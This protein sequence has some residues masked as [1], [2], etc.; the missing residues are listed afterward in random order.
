MTSPG[1]FRHDWRFLLPRSSLHGTVVLA[2]DRDGSA[3]GALG[4]SGWFDGVRDVDDRSSEPASVVVR[5]AD[6]VG[7]L[8]DLDRHVGDETVVLV[9]WPDRGSRLRHRREAAR[10]WGGTRAARDHVVFPGHADARWCAPVGAPAALRWYLDHRF[11]PGSRA[12][13]VAVAVVRLASRTPAAGLA[14]LAAPA[15]ITVWTPRSWGPA[16]VGPSEGLGPEPLL[17]SSAQDA[18]SRAVMLGFDGG[19]PT[20]LAK[21]STTPTT[22][23]RTVEEVA[24]LRLVEAV[25]DAAG[26][27]VTVPRS[28][29][30]GSMGALAWNRQTVVRGV[31]ADR[32]IGA[33]ARGS[34]LDAVTLLERVVDWSVAMTRASLAPESW[35]AAAVADRVVGPALRALEVLPAAEQP[36]DLA[37]RLEALRSRRP[38]ATIPHALAHADLAPCNVVV[39]GP[40]VGVVDWERPDVGFGPGD[41]RDHGPVGVDLS[42][43]ASYWLFQR[44][45]AT[46]IDDEVRLLRALLGAPA[47]DADADADP[48]RAARAAL[49][50]FH[51]AIGTDPDVVPWVWVLLWAQRLVASAARAEG[52]PSPAVVRNVAASA[53]FLREA[54]VALDAAPDSSTSS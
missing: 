40:V 24:R 3:A 22:N 15:T 6:H 34:A 29:A 31:G 17:F 33:A 21:V 12:L 39:D 36:A 43:F 46:R 52:S 25:A 27:G 45:G 32:I 48:V 53:Q 54:L 8:A 9:E 35:S 23:D 41:D 47:R 7:P 38:P 5:L 13:A 30:S 50:R 26:L 14:V 16:G 20:S 19:D 2:G 42:F 1:R 37:R 44:A 10:R 28:V 18:A 51:S 11:I 49:A 4:A